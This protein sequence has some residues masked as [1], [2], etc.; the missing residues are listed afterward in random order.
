M[1][2]GAK[3]A[4][5]EQGF[6]SEM[7]IHEYIQYRTAKSIKYEENMMSVADEKKTVDHNSECYTM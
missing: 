2:R 5:N 6:G 1:D 4:D 3:K 7:W